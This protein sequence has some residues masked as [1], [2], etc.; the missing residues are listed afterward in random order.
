MSSP[1]DRPTSDEI[2]AALARILDSRAF[3]ASPQLTAFL[4]FVVEAE[5]A[6]A[7]D[8]IKGYTI[9][10]EALGRSE[11]FDPQTDPIV[12]V[13]AARLRR[14]LERYY[15]E[16][17]PAEQVV[18]DL[19]RGSYAPVFSRA[20]VVS[21]SGPAFLRR[22][23][24]AL[25]WQ[26]SFCTVLGAIVI[27]ILGWA[28]F[29]TFVH[30][31]RT[32]L[33]TD[34]GS[35]NET[36]VLGTSA[37]QRFVEP[38]LSIEPI[39]VIGTPNATAIS[40]AW[41]QERLF[42]AL[43]RFDGIQVITDVTAATTPADD[44][45]ARFRAPATDYRLAGT[46]DH[47]SAGGATL[48]VRL[49]DTRL[50]AVFWS[51]SF[52]LPRGSEE[53]STTQSVIK[54]V[55]STLI[56]PYGAIHSRELAR[57]TDATHDLFFSCTHRT[58]EY[59]WTRDPKLGP[60]AA[61]GC[62]ERAISV[63]PMFARGHSLLAALYLSEYRFGAAPDAERDKMVERAITAA[64]TAVRLKPGSV[65]ALAVLADVLLARGQFADAQAAAERAVT[66]NPLD[67]IAVYYYATA[68]VFAGELDKG[69]AAVR[70]VFAAFPDPPQRTYFVAFVA[71]HLRG[72]V[73]K[74][75]QHASYMSTSTFG[76]ALLARAL[77]AW[78][79]GDRNGAR[80]AIETLFESHPAWKTE[81]QC[82][83]KRI[84][85]LPEMADRFTADFAAA[86][87]FAMP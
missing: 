36:G 14:A 84:F 62:L 81:P 71:S 2:R 40:A 68:L 22:I 28:I 54:T 67:P 19:P 31:R 16:A 23:S 86:V 47:R 50:N 21:T 39:R 48:I 46:I 51:R 59:L 49:V 72:D 38:T 76:P 64:R 24:D 13:E 29:D 25:H 33:Q 57:H 27:G 66:L 43:V 18:I 7:R 20:G 4:R 80:Q 65:R 34:A 26:P 83:L 37:R 74:E 82:E 85:P 8:R 35:V 1:S 9:A 42:D 79:T 15:A 6:G 10:V 70:E 87:R 12:R 32:Y 61:R 44:M 77:A 75:V 11:E 30:D 45:V 56:E 5:L 69:D 52:D 73:A 55:A 58:Y 78:K 3:R 17:D 60:A 53:Q 41:L 63:D